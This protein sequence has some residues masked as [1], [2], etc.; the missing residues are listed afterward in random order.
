[1]SATGE[2]ERRHARQLRIRAGMDVCGAYQEQYIGTVVGVVTGDAGRSS[3]RSRGATAAQTGS[4][5]SAAHGSP[6]LVHEEG[7]AASP[8]VQVGRRILGEELGPVPTIALGNGGPSR[9]SAGQNYATGGLDEP[10]EVR[11]IVVRPGRFN[12]LARPLYVPVRAVRS[13]SMERVVLGVRKS[14]LPPEWR[15]RRA[16]DD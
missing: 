8:E 5:T 7:H 13:I 11:G 16:I 10:A 15:H 4:A 14:E 9:Q 6:R 2:V 12:P 3:P 1:M